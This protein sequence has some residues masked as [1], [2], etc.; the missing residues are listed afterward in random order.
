[1]ILAITGHRPDKLDNDYSYTKPIS[2]RLYEIFMEEISM[3]RPDKCISGMAQG[4]DTIFANAAIKSGISLIAA[5]PFKGQESMWPES[6]K[7]IY[8]TILGHPLTTS[9]IICDGGYHPS[10]M[11]TRN[12]WMVDNCDELIAV[13]NGSPGGTANCRNYAIKMNK[14]IINIDP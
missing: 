1:M 7:K 8:Y 9:K 4:V 13:W 2:K 11:Q 10:K 14:T 3:R 6:A 5:I 12:M